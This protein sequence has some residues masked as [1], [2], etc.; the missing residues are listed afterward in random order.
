MAGRSPTTLLL[1]DQTSQDVDALAAA[2]RD[3]CRT[4][5]ATS[6]RFRDLAHPR[7][8]WDRA[9]RRKRGRGRRLQSRAVAYADSVPP[10]RSGCRPGRSRTPDS[11]ERNVANAITRRGAAAAQERSHGPASAHRGGLDN[12]REPSVDHCREPAPR[13]AVRPTSLRAELSHVARDLNEKIRVAPIRPGTAPSYVR[14]QAPP[15][16]SPLRLDPRHR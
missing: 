8:G 9:D 10:H 13:L 14:G 3:R 11:G 16:S 7:C 15:D 5:P 4:T 6:A 1:C 2:Q 12:R